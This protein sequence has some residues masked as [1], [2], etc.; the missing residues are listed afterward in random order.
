M[1]QTQAKTAVQDATTT[2]SNDQAQVIATANQIPELKDV[3]LSG[4]MSVGKELGRGA[5]GKVYSVRGV[6]HYQ[7]LRTR[8]RISLILSANS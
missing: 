5:Y 4:T 6:R 1:G 3:T 7:K 2:A 8:F